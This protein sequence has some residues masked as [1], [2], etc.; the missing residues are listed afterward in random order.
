MLPQDIIEPTQRHQVA[1]D[2]IHRALRE[3]DDDG[4]SDE[5]MDDKRLE[6]AIRE[7]YIAL[8]CQ[9]VGSAHF[10]SP[11]ISFCAM[12]SRTRLFSS[13]AERGGRKDQAAKKGTGN[14]ELDE[15]AR[16]RRNL[17]C[18]YDPGNYSSALSALIWSA[19]LVL[20]ESVCFQERDNEDRVPAALARVCEEFMHQKGETAFGHIL[21]W[22]LYTT[23]VARSAIRRRQARWSLCGER[24]D[25]LGT[26]LHMADVTRLILY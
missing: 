20:F 6:A 25:Y 4:I 26:S 14:D 19:Q 22:R 8:I 17:R 24:I 10:P 1:M 18:W 12:L 7:F 23:T 13:G 15:A 3:Q 2:E 11:V 16:R 5:D 9:T 21:Q